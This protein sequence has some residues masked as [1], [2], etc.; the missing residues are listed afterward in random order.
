MPLL[1]CSMWTCVLPVLA[2][3]L[4]G[5]GGGR[6]ARCRGAQVPRPQ[7]QDQ[8][9]HQPVRRASGPFWLRPLLRALQLPHMIC[10]L[11]S[12]QQRVEGGQLQCASMR[13]EQL[14]WK[15]ACCMHA[16]VTMHGAAEPSY[17]AYRISQASPLGPEY[18]HSQ[19]TCVCI[20]SWRARQPA[21]YMQSTGEPDQAPARR[22]TPLLDRLDSVPMA[23]MSQV[24]VKGWR[25]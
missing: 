25:A 4:H 16:H 24:H 20:N 17:W 11:L 23:E 21:M 22:Y 1:V 14:G 2:Q 10:M 12:T 8:L 18:A 5:G 7:G 13:L 3:V 6:G 9:P 19:H 15:P